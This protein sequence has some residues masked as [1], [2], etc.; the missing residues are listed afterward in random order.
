MIILFSLIP[1]PCAIKAPVVVEAKEFSKVYATSEGVLRKLFFKNGDHISN[2]DVI[3]QLSNVDLETETATVKA[4]LHQNMALKQRAMFEASDD[5]KPI[6]VREQMLRDQLRHL[7]QK[8]AGL[9]IVAEST[10]VFVAPDTE[11]FMGRW[12]KRQTRLGS[13]IS[14][15]DFKCSA[16]VSQ[17]QAFNLFKEKKLTAAIKLYG[18]S[19]EELNVH[20]ILVIPYQREELPSAALGWFGGGDVSVSSTD[21]SGKKTVEPF[22]EVIGTLDSGKGAPTSLLHGRSGIL[23]MKLPPEPLSVQLY[24]LVKQTIQKR[25]KV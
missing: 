3:A 16:I 21:K 20:D 17:E 24:R 4:G 6:A 12:L 2:G 7:E 11:S 14:S 15:G 1:F 10:G 22:F 9:T 8:K 13:V 25:Y 19:D 23:R 5:L 18:Q